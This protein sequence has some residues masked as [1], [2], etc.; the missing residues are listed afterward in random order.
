MKRWVTRK[1]K[2][3]T[4]RPKSKPNWFLCFPLIHTTLT[5]V[6]SSYSDDEDTSYKIRRSATKLL[7]AVI[8]TRPELLTSIYKEVSPVLI[9][10]FGDREETVRLEVWATYGVLLVQTSHYGGLY[11]SQAGNI[12]TR[13]KKRDSDGMDVED[14]S[15]AP[16]VLLRRQVPAFAKALLKQ[17]RPKAAP[18]TLQAGF[19]LLRTLLD[20]LPGSLSGQVDLLKD[21]SVPVLSQV[22]TTTNSALH[23]TCLS[24]WSLFFATHPPTTFAA[25]L[26][27]LTP[28][29]LNFLEEKHPRLAS[30][31]FKVF[32]ALLNAVKP[33]KAADWAD[34]LYEEAVKR[35]SSHDTDA[36]VREAVEDVIADLWICATDVMRG[37]GGKEWDM[38]CRPGGKTDGA[39]RVVTKI[40]REAQVGDNW[41]NGCI[42]WLVL[43]LQKG[44]RSGKMEIFGAMN[45]LLRRFVQ[46]ALPPNGTDGIFL[47]FSYQVVPEDLP[48]ILIPRIRPYISTSDISLLSHTLSIVALLLELSPSSA[49]PEV[50][51]DL[52]ADIY[53]ISHSVL[54]SGAALDSTLGFFSALV[55]ADAEIATHVV[56]NLVVA[57]DKAHKS[58]VSPSNVAKCIAQVIKG[59]PAVAAGTIAEFS[60]HLK[61]SF[62]RLLY[63]RLI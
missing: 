39:V 7:T 5:F 26:Q 51:R 47:F 21:K 13:G 52:L 31:S 2:M 32:S 30:E 60:K 44:G 46:V 18:S 33:V 14:T 59:A 36:A 58:D 11:L 22:P 8:G 63:T 41:V 40:G 23:L 62:R 12:T 55:Q 17:L 56:L 28:L 45:V 38:I 27:L 57:V 19:H 29:L 6:V 35:L 48:T 34:K 50:E 24:F 4:M 42:E 3:M 49:F 10:R 9:S 53:N 15:E 20:V 16:F 54:V 43:L 25:S 37:K 1:T 61:V